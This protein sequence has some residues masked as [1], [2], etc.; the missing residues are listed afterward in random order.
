M[1][2]P[3]NLKGKKF[4]KLT[5]LNPIGLDQN[6]QVKWRCKCD[7]GASHMATASRLNKGRTKSC[8]CIKTTIALNNLQLANEARANA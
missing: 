3:L 7:C 8:G 1:P 4:G 2:A 5:A 6:G